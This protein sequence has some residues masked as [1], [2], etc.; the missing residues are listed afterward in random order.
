MHLNALLLFLFAVGVRCTTPDVTLAPPPPPPDTLNSTLTIVLAIVGGM[1]FIILIA[2]VVYVC[3][4]QSAFRNEKQK[5]AETKEKNKQ[6]LL[7]QR[8]DGEAQAMNLMDRQMDELKQEYNNAYIEHIKFI[9]DHD[10]EWFEEMKDKGYV[11][12]DGEDSVMSDA[13]RDIDEELNDLRTENKMRPDQLKFTKDEKEELLRNTDKTN[14]AKTLRRE[15]RS[16]KKLRKERKDISSLED[17][18]LALEQKLADLDLEEKMVALAQLE[19]K[20]RERE[21]MDNLRRSKRLA[22]AAN[23][24]YIISRMGGA[25]MD[26]D[27]EPYDSE[28][29]FDDRL[30]ELPAHLD[31]TNPR[32]KLLKEKLDELR[33]SLD[34]QKAV[35]SKRENE[36]D[37]DMT[38]M[39]LRLQQ[40]NRTIARHERKIVA[41]LSKNGA[42]GGGGGVTIQEPSPDVEVTKHK[43][44]K[45]PHFITQPWNVD[46]IRTARPRRRG[47]GGGGDRGDSG[48]TEHHLLSFIADA[49]KD[50]A[51]QEDAL[52]SGRYLNE[53]DE[54]AA[55]SPLR[56]GLHPDALPTSR[57]PTSVQSKRTML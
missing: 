29:D 27:L 15:M 43:H 45:V 6:D 9:K 2:V 32:G 36:I 1:L 34:N 12:I 19:K 37:R 23:G 31:D 30:P 28:F 25:A 41:N 51:A 44:E 49:M 50:P 5:I 14:T 53:E 47:K 10:P 21:E 42:G 20:Q 18:K 54:Y 38:L 4:L 7:S 24:E 22:V 13:S 56:T 55:G 16:L 3:Q 48:N 17:E 35:N 26:Y 33:V 57:L 46:G 52:R 11:L 8:D 40:Q 39:R